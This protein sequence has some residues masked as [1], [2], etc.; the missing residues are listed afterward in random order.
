MVNWIVAWIIL[1]F[2]VLVGGGGAYNELKGGRKKKLKYS[3]KR[4]GKK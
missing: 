2:I 4:K 1:A 3:K